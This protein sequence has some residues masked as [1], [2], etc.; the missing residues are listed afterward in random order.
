MNPPRSDPAHHRRQLARRDR[1]QEGREAQVLAVV[2]RLSSS[3][4]VAAE[5][6]RDLF[7]SSAAVAVLALHDPRLVGMKLQ[8]DP[9]KPTRDRIPHLAGLTFADAMD[10]RIVCKALERDRRELP[11]HPRIK[12]V[13]QKQ[14]GEDRRDRAAI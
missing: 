11:D 3:E 6:E 9:D 8:P 13:M 10:H 1:R 4:R 7:I 14:V 5:R 12:P 2:V